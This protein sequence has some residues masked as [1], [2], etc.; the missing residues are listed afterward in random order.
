MQELKPVMLIDN[1]DLDNFINQKTLEYYG[2]TTI[3][4]FKNVSRALS[5]L[6]ETDIIYQLIL[7]DLYMPLINGFE[8]IDKFYELELYKTQGQVCLL[9]SSI[10]PLDKEI[11]A[12]KNIKFIEKPLTIEKLQ[13]HTK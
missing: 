1:E 6:T 11:S 8:F 13:D 10:N 2:A 4:I 9:T 5:Y 3:K 12:E 7:V